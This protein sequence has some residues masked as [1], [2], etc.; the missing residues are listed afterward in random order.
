MRNETLTLSST[1]VAHATRMR[2]ALPVG[3][4]ATVTVENRS[5]GQVSTRSVSVLA[6]VGDVA[7]ST[8][9]VKVL[10]SEGYR[11]LSLW[12]ISEVTR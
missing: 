6:H 7:N 9:A 10:T 3:S 2:D 8:G 4:S 5:T 12:L 1:S 11:T